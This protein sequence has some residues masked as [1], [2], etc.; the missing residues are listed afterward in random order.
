MEFVG[1]KWCRGKRFVALAAL[2][3]DRRRPSSTGCTPRSEA[4]SED[5]VWSFSSIL[6]MPTVDLCRQSSSHVQ[7]Q[8]V[9][10]LSVTYGLCLPIWVFGLW[11][12][13][14]LPSF[15]RLWFWVMCS[16]ISSFLS[17]LSWEIDSA[18]SLFMECENCVFLF[19]RM[20]MVECSLLRYLLQDWSIPR[21]GGGSSI[22]AH[23]YLT[24]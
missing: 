8:V 3:N 20:L 14:K 16:F 15:A 24:F 10:F 23:A 11:A 13:T 12:C 5:K 2:L 17:G 4:S 18:R 19:G 21:S 1:K 6:P 9:F 22:A 7:M